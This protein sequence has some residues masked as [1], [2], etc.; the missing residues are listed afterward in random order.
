MKIFLDVGGHLGETV[1][2]VIDPRFG[3]DRIYSF[4]PVAQCCK[5]IRKIRDSRLIVVQAGMLNETAERLIFDPGSIAGSIYQDHIHLSNNNKELC[6]FIE[7]AEFFEKNI[8]DSDV[9][10][11]KLNCE[12]SECAIIE[13]LIVKNQFSK[14]K[15]VLID[16]D[17]QKIPSQ[18]GE[19]RKIIK[20]LNNIKARNYHFPEEVQ[21]GFVNHFGGIQNWLTKTSAVEKDVHLLIKSFVFHVGNIIWGRH[22]GYYKF[23]ILRLLPKRVV[24][25]YYDKVK[26]RTL[27]HS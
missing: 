26:K 23:R 10:Y 4:E 13:N 24:G 8:S 18:F 5:Q 14:I 19:D 1:E 6:S 3:F 27:N 25:F 22:I 7:A 20:L 16:F 15:E 17:V 12:G 9:V 2:A 21:Y 11:M